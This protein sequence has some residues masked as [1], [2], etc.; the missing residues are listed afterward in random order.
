MSL[1]QIVLTAR[2]L[3]ECFAVAV[4]SE[5]GWRSVGVELWMGLSTDKQQLRSTAYTVPS[6][7]APAKRIK[8]YLRMAQHASTVYPSTRHPASIRALRHP[9]RAYHG[10]RTL[11]VDH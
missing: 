6:K 5:Q 7:K 3:N 4:V 10:T 9:W 11:L 8:D 1:A 2:L